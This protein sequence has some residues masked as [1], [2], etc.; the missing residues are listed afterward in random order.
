MKRIAQY[1]KF[2]ENCERY[3][4]IEKMKKELSLAPRRNSMIEKVENNQKQKVRRRSKS[5][6]FEEMCCKDMN[7]SSNDRS[8]LPQDL[9]DQEM[10]LNQRMELWK[11]SKSPQGCKIWLNSSSLAALVEV[12]NQEKVQRLKTQHS[13]SN[14]SY[15]T[16]D[17]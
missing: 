3:K 13:H 16:E 8:S 14:E 5:L 2:V 6:S 11:S 15:V 10:T 7:K 12:T 4:Q 9:N 1:E 17:V